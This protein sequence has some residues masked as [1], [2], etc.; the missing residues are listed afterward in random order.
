MEEQYNEMRITLE[1]LNARRRLENY[2]R[3][4]MGNKA[5]AVRER[6]FLTGN[7][8]FRLRLQ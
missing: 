3:L 6:G 4:L 5:L 1:I 2:T 8:R 7:V